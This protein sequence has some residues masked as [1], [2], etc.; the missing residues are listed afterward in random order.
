MDAPRSR[1][2]ARAPGTLTISWGRLRFQREALASLVRSWWVPMALGAIV[3]LAAAVRLYDLA[4]NPPGFFADEASYGYNAYSLLHPRKDEDGAPPP[5][6]FKAFGEY[7]LPVY[8]YSQIPFIAAL[9][10]T[11]TAVRLTTATYG[12]LTVVALYLLVR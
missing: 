10:L 5:P 6:F 3:V 4:A 12:I 1:P 9:G 7:K 11:E 2:A 8:I